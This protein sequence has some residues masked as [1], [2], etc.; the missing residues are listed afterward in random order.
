MRCR[1]KRKRVGDVFPVRDSYHY[2]LP[3]GLAPGTPVKLVA[4]ACGYWTVEASGEFYRVFGPLV[5]AGFEYEIGEKWFPANHPRVIAAKKE[6]ANRSAARTPPNQSWGCSPTG[7]QE[8]IP[9]PHL[10]AD[11]SMRSPTPAVCQHPAISQTHLRA[12]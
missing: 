2:P 8:S 7:L 11:E 3:S 1:E 6:W 4:Y 9:S 12:G 10:N 5:D